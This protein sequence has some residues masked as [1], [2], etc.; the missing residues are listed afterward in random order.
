[1]KVYVI[2]SVIFPFVA[3]PRRPL[4]GDGT[5]ED[6]VAESGGLHTRKLDLIV[7]SKSFTYRLC[8]GVHTSCIDFNSYNIAINISLFCLAQTHLS[9]ASEVIVSSLIVASSRLTLPCSLALKQ[10]CHRAQHFMHWHFSLQHR[11]WHCPVLSDSNKSVIR[12][13][14][15]LAQLFFTIICMILFGTIV[16]TI[17]LI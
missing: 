7:D 15:S 8:I 17:F 14:T 2:F 6:Y 1:M 12:R 5:G 4:R 3:S 9:V 10:I 13:N 16:G 11:V